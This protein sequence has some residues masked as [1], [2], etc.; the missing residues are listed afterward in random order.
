M[1]HD[2]PVNPLI[3]PEEVDAALRA[4]REGSAREFDHLISA[5]DGPGICECLQMVIK[6][7]GERPKHLKTDDPP[8]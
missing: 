4:F 5:E 3:R 7:M 6:K 1:S 2:P 8:T